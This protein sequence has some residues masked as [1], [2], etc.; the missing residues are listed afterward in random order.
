MLCKWSLCEGFACDDNTPGPNHRETH[1][2]GQSISMNPREASSRMATHLNEPTTISSYDN[3]RV[4]QYLF[5]IDRAGALLLCLH[6]NH[7]P[8]TRRQSHHPPNHRPTHSR[9]SSLLNFQFSS[10][11][12]ILSFGDGGWWSTRTELRLAKV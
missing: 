11:L 7:L 2:H 6:Y 8:P 5:A 9:G 1:T 10:S 12:R 4:P 3:G